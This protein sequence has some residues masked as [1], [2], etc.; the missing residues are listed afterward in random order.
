M[1]AKS[2]ANCSTVKESPQVYNEVME[3][4]KVFALNLKILRESREMTARELGEKVGVTGKHIY[5]LENDRKKPSIDLL[6]E[7][8]KAFNIS[9]SELLSS[10]KI[11]APVRIAGKTTDLLKE[12]IIRREKIPDDVIDMAQGFEPGDEV[13]DEVRVV[14]GAALRLRDHDGHKK[15]QGA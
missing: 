4:T 13:W 6:E 5:D 3:I 14:F 12:L 8:A 10:K 2:V 15:S 9:I 7:I 11:L 1:Q